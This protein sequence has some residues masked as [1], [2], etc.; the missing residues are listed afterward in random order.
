MHPDK[1][2]AGPG[3]GVWVGGFGDRNCSERVIICQ[4][5]SKGNGNKKT[6]D[7]CWCGCREKGTLVHC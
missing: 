1:I 3:S 5:V 4:E 2:I 6:K 7:K